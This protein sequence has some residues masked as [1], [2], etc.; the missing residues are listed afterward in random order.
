MLFGK[1][2]QNIIL[3]GSRLLAFALMVLFVMPIFG[4]DEEKTVYVCP[5]CDRGSERS[6]DE[7]RYDQAGICPICR[8][9]LVTLKSLKESQEAA[10]HLAAQTAEPQ[11]NAKYVC[12]PCAR[13]CDNEVHDKPGTCASCNMKLVVKK[14]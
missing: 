8:M 9:E 6:C 10:K 1:L 5:P 7:E 14:E 13:A 11:Q 4:G 12:P 2:H 3:G